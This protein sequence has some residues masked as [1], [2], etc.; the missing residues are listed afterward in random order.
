MAAISREPQQ[1]ASTDKTTYKTSDTHVG[2]RAVSEYSLS[3][4]SWRDFL[5]LYIKDAGPMLLTPALDLANGNFARFDVQR[6][7]PAEWCFDVQRRCA[8]IKTGM[9]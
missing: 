8:G 7:R 3:P 6:R 2:V 9:L 5:S 4:A 1:R